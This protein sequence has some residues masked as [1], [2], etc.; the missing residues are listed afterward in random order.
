[1][2]MTRTPKEGKMRDSAKFKKKKPAKRGAKSGSGRVPGN[3]GSDSSQ[4]LL[5]S[6]FCQE[7]RGAPRGVTK[8][9]DA[10]EF[11]N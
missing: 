10:R 5:S 9:K 6:Y 8:T 2:M 4:L 3:K 11:G 1:M 7:G